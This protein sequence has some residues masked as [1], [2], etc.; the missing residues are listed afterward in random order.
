MPSLLK[1]AGSLCSPNGV[2]LLFATIYVCATFVFPLFS[3][4]AAS[5]G[6]SG[7]VKVVTDGF[8]WTILFNTFKLSAIVAA[9]TLLVAYP[10][11]MRACMA[12]PRM[13]LI[14]LIFMTVPMWTSLLA[15]SYAWISV[16][17]R[18]G[19]VNSVL[20]SLQITGSP[21]KL[22]HTTG[23]TVIGSI[24]I[25]L[26]MMALALFAQ[27]SKIDLTT[28]KAARTLGAGPAQ[29]FLRVFLPL[30]FPGIVSG[31]VLTFIV[32]LGLFVTPVLLGGPQDRTFSML[33]E[34]E[35]NTFGNFSR[36]AELSVFLLVVSGLLLLVLL[37]LTNRRQRPGR[38]AKAITG[39]RAAGLLARLIVMLRIFEM[40]WFWN[41]VI[42]AVLA[43]IMLP[44]V[45]LVPMSLGSSNYLEFPPKTYSLR[46]YDALFHDSR[47]I[48]AFLNSLM[49]GLLA[50][51]ISV[52]VGTSAALAMRDRRQRGARLIA[53]L[54]V[55]PSLIPPMVYAIG[56]YIT[57]VPL[58]LQDSVL[59]LALAHSALAIPFVFIISETGLAGIG[60][61]VEQAAQ[62]LGARWTSRVWRITLPLLIPSIAVGGL[63]AFI[64]SFD[65]I[66]V[67]LF[68]SGIHVQ[69]LPKTFW[70]AAILEVTPIVPAAAV[71]IMAAGLT[72]VSVA[73]LMLHLSRSRAGRNPSSVF[74]GR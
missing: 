3:M 16:L 62:S 32:S 20:T 61:R 51:L 31:T 19:L 46:W 43:F 37:R 4:L 17:D 39:T 21:L 7:Y 6:L 2:L 69:T 74:I 50:A 36:A 70:R 27:M 11:A 26:P 14:L 10:L 35:V 56:A 29:T 71:T 38:R 52:V 33:I 73:A 53:P 48:T 18:R 45:T 57:S 59:G 44:L 22:L 72:V 41:V 54:F 25:M 15:R 13:R 9:G 28:L 66:V 64:T 65:E 24:Y 55:A 58:G 47:W 12:G 68:L 5:E 60:E 8:Y 49:V 30:S 63:I 42:L 1:R 34:Q 67:A 23:A 40:R